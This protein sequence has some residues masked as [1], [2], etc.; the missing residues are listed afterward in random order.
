LRKG[1]GA[2]PHARAAPDAQEGETMTAAELVSHEDAR[3][4]AAARRREA[5][6]G[7]LRGFRHEG[8]RFLVWDED[9]TTAA[10]WAAELLR[11]ETRDG[12]KR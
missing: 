3:R 1:S 8:R 12:G 6:P 2:G 4:R 10:A 11:A 9:G 7:A 5:R